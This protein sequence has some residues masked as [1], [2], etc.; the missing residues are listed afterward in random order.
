MKI[1]LHLIPIMSIEYTNNSKIHKSPDNLTK[2]NQVFP[3]KL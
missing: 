3:K 1:K 2:S